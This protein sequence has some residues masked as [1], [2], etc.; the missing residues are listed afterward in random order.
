M[1]KGTAFISAC[2][3]PVMLRSRWCFPDEQGRLPT[4]WCEGCGTEMFEKKKL[5]YRCIRRMENETDTIPLHQLPKDGR[6]RAV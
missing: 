2:R 6:S 5:C 3:R 1:C 4:S